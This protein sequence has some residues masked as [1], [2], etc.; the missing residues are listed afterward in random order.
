MKNNKV[1]IITDSVSMPRPDVD[2]ESTWIYLLKKKYPNLDIMDRSA[3]GST[4]RRLVTE[5]GGGFDLLESYMPGLVILQLGLAEC[6][7]RLFRKQGFEFYFMNKILSPVSRKRYINFI[8][9]RRK[10]KP[11][12]SETSPDEFRN[13][14]NQYMQRCL[15]N[16]TKLII[17]KILRPTDLYIS[18]S[19]L[20]KECID[21]SNNII[22]ELVK[23]YNNVYV[24]NP[25]KESVDV[26]KICLDELHIDK[27]GNNLF[28]KEIDKCIM[29][30][31]SSL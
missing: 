13:N 3:R 11:E 8:K 4:S 9:K 14:L 22:D 21:R 24:V 15:K 31:Y 18:K 25:V 16:N 6:A 23:H 26:N 1:I 10:R 12:L 7:P 2:Y 17:I 27:V 19:P 29:K 30:L 5:G 28:F 20:I